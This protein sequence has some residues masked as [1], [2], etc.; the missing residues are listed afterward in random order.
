M[1]KKVNQLQITFQRNAD[2]VNGGIEPNAN[3]IDE[4]IDLA[5]VGRTGA[6]KPDDKGLLKIDLGRN[7][8]S[9]ASGTRI[10]DK[11]ITKGAMKPE[12][13][14]AD[15]MLVINEAGNN[16]VNKWGTIRAEAPG[17]GDSNDVGP[18]TKR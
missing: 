5:L 1:K 3:N 10:V 12:R 2:S 15:H 16:I 14:H 7:E 18:S 6:E 9:G 11:S 4:R 17:D 13:R 8:R